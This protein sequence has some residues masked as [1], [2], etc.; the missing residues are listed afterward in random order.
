MSGDIF[1]VNRFNWM[2]WLQTL[3]TNKNCFDLLHISKVNNYLKC[4]WSLAA[5]R[6][7]EVTDEGLETLFAANYFG[8]F[9][10]TNLLLGKCHFCLEMLNK[11]A[12]WYRNLPG[13]SI[14]NV[15]NQQYIYKNTDIWVILPWSH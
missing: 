8:P 14:S 10:L 11:S 12:L 5:G 2:H 7:R 3:K 6:S 1:T 9:L 13:N 15:C 4:Y